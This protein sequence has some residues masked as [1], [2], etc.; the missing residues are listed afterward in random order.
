VNGISRNLPVVF[1]GSLSIFGSGSQTF[2]NADFG[3]SVTY[4]G[5]STVSISVPPNY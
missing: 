5:R 4:D 2:V 3:L 1:N